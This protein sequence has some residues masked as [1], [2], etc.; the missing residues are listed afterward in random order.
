MGRKK[1]G[2]MSANKIKISF[3]I[4]PELVET[5][6]EIADKNGRKLS[7]LIEEAVEKYLEGTPTK[8]VKTEIKRRVYVEPAST[9]EVSAN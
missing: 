4:N 9:H 2:D 6:T 8:P 5:L 1:K 3:T 7:S